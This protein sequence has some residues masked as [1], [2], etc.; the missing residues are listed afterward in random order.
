MLSTNPLGRY[1]SGTTM[2]LADLLQHTGLPLPDPSDP[3]ALVRG[4]TEDSRLVKPGWVFIA[5]P[6]LHADGRRFI[7]DA[8]NAGAL[9][10]VTD[11]HHATRPHHPAVQAPILTTPYPAKA[12]AILAETLAGNP[13]AHLKLVGVTGTNGKS[14][15]T[16][17]ISQIATH[18]RTP[19]GLIGTVQIDDGS[20]QVP[21]DF[22]T[23]PAER[24]SPML[25]RM[26]HN[27]RTAAAIEVSSH[28]L[29]QHRVAGLTFAAAVFTNLTGDHLD[30][31]KDM[32]AYAAAKASLFAMLDP[33]PDAIA[34]VNA[35]DPATDT[36]LEHCNARVLACAVKD[37]PVR[38][39][40]HHAS[41]SPTVEILATQPTG[42]HLRFTGLSRQSGRQP[43]TIET[44]T[45]LFGHHN[46]MNLLQAVVVCIEAFD[47][48]PADVAAALPTLR[49]PTGRLERIST[50]ADPITVF[51][52]FAHTD[53]ALA[54]ALR[55]A[56]LVTPKDANLWVVFGCGGNKDRA[57]RPRMGHAAATLADMVVATSDNPRTEDPEAI[58]D[59]IVAGI[60][61]D[62]RAALH[63]DPDRRAAINAAIAQANPGDVVVIAGKGHEREQILADSS[64]NTRTIPFD[65]HEIAR[66]ALR[67]R[68]NPTPSQ[69][70]P[71]V[72]EVASGGASGSSSAGGT[73]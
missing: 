66:Q 13:S 67:A 70:R 22:T 11:D 50:D 24:L 7:P 63:R 41:T 38:A 12:G 35:N 55:A 40:S 37:T 44:K 27:N 9:L 69:H 36:M 42:T 8:I 1:A 21:S 57:K 71:P 52:D 68:N 16:A 18:A 15:V 54:S 25:A 17:L 58:L 60:P 29:C 49:T 45:T 61:T 64:G 4:I 46:A 14:T 48:H 53:D 2:H 72:T 33:H 28:A 30:Y 73:P 6:G 39:T 19:C 26:V 31:H 62:R 5:R 34:V 47:I 20:N 3:R 23:P 51:V 56:R 10:I 65:D 43:H 59:E 32:H